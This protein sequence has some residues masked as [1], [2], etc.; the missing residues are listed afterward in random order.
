MT[1]PDTL[2]RASERLIDSARA[3]L[4]VRE[5]GPLSHFVRVYREWIA[6]ERGELGT[7]QAQVEQ[8]QMLVHCMISAA[9]VEEAVQL[10]VR[11]SRVVWADRA[12]AGTRS[13]QGH[14]ALIF[15]EPH[16]EGP[17]GLT[18]VLWM[19]SLILST[20]E[21]LAGVRFVNAS[22]RVRHASCLPE[23]VGGLLFHSPIVFGQDEVALLVPQ[24]DMRRPV[25]AKGKDL[26]GFFR[27]LL[28][29]TLGAINPALRMRELVAGLIRQHK[30]GP[31]YR[32]AGRPDLAAALG[33]SDATLRRRLRDEGGTFREI[34]D[35]V[36]DDLACGWLRE[37]VPVAEVAAR[38][39]FS[40][41]FA[42]R[43]FFH[44]LHHCAPSVWRTQ[45]RL[46]GV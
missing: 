16:R 10:L 14:V 24:A 1:K 19:Q 12:L 4:G 13:G 45:E 30:Q 26:P 18:A 28:P 41:A 6:L 3:T 40:D 25:T 32:D 42:F 7:Q 37:A 46:D 44:R 21:F 34:R 17:A 8:W 23:G 31:D 9:T 22:G 43:R 33:V 15:N 27:E 38:L 5:M 39:G 36:F 2:E 29:M 11:F 35:E 20:L